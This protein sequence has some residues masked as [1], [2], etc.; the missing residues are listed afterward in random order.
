MKDNDN[1]KIFHKKYENQQMLE[2]EEQ[3]RNFKK[4]IQEMDEKFT[5]QIE[6]LYD[7]HDK[8]F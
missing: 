4:S 1:E 2:F 8:I 6:R 3:L 7:N 5:C